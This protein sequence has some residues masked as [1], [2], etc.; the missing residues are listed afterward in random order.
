[1]IWI[2]GYFGFIGLIVCV[3]KLGYYDAKME[4]GMKRVKESLEKMIK[5][6]DE[7]PHEA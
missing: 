1:M 7:P 3:Y 4:D 2:I 6:A 5:P